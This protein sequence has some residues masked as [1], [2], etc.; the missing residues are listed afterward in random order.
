MYTFFTFRFSY[1]VFIFRN[2]R[3]KLYICGKKSANLTLEIKDGIN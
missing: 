2:D 3:N 1:V